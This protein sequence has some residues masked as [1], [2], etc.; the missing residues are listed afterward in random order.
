[1]AKRRPP[2]P[3]R[4]PCPLCGRPLRGTFCPGCGWDRDINDSDDSYLDGVE[5]PDRWEEDPPPGEGGVRPLWKAVAL[6]IVLAF[7]WWLF[8]RI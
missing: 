8:S 4:E 3:P 6:A 1:M 7:A 5:I 2:P